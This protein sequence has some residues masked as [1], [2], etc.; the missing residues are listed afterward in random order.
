ML[1]MTMSSPELIISASRKLATFSP[2]YDE[3]KVYPLLS[4]ACDAYKNSPASQ[5]SNSQLLMKVFNIGMKNGITFPWNLILYTR[6][7]MHLDGMVLNLC[8]DFVFS[9]YSRQKFLEMYGEMMIKDILSLPHIV[10]K[11]GDIIEELQRYGR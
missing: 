7:A 10:E 3:N 5:M 4:E 9:E 6:S 8:P 1:G 2:E 11:A